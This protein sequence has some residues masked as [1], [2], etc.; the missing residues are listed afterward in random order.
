MTTLLK[1]T[2][3]PVTPDRYENRLGRRKPILIV[4]VLL[5]SLF[6]LFSSASGLMAGFVGPLVA[7]RASDLWGLQAARFIAAGGAALVVALSFGLRETAP[8]VLRRRGVVT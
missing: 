8:A 1:R 7:G 6:S 4:A 3:P 5:F 2:T